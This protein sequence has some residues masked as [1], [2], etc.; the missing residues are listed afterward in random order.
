MARKQIASH[1][2]HTL[3]AIGLNENE[4][5]LYQILLSHPDSTVQELQNKTPFPRTLLYHLLNRLIELG[6]AGA[7]KSEWPMRYRV[8][9]PERLY[10]LLER[11]EKEFHLSAEAVKKLVPDLKNQYRLSGHRLNT[12]L[13][14]GLDGYKHALQ[15]IL[16]ST[17][18][19][20][21]AFEPVEEH[22]SGFEIRDS[23][24]QQ[25]LRKK[26]EKRVVS[27]DTPKL[28]ERYKQK[29]YNDFTQIRVSSSLT[30]H[31]IA[32][33]LIY[34]DKLL[35]TSYSDRE[36]ITLIIEDKTLCAMQ[37]FF[38]RV[39]WEQATDITLSTYER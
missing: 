13:F 7:N 18:K 5:V 38:F 26:I 16:L 4:A 39:L 11:K 3:E 29:P 34:N 30:S 27:A 31:S 24:E 14:D 6:L 21:Y 25:R 12:R 33:L 32:D 8:E 37:T 20:L 28:R 2:S 9:N 35:Y 17:P 23:W 19:I 22:R 15:D 36:P 1:T 10:D